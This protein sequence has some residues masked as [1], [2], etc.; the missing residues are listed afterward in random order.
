M[1]KFTSWWQHLGLLLIGFFF[2][3][4]LSVGIIIYVFI[5]SLILAYLHSLDDR[6]RICILY[7]SLL[8]IISSMLSVFQTFIIYLFVFILG[9][10]YTFYISKK[11]I[12]AFYK[13]FGFSL[14]MFIPAKVFALNSIPLYILLSLVGIISELFHEAEHFEQD[15]KEGRTTTAIYFNFKATKGTRNKIKLATITIGVVLLICLILR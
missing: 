5:A 1:Y 3:N 2:F 13:G 11:P 8:I 7:A 10:L 14:L 12:S 4:V 6:K 15:K 9:P